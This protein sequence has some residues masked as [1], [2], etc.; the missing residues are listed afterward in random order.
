MNN[1]NDSDS[2]CKD[3]YND[4]G[5]NENINNKNNN[6][7]NNNSNSNNINSNNI[8]SNNNRNSNTP[9]IKRTTRKPSKKAELPK[10][11]DSLLVELCNLDPTFPE[12]KVTTLDVD[13]S[14]YWS[15]FRGMKDGER[16]NIYNKEVWEAIGVDK[17]K[18]IIV[19]TTI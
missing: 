12:V 16:R 13:R 9:N 10:I 1:N 11:T 18:G 8:N 17:C 5:S 2:D 7:N 4:S 14:H 6:R 19:V 15:F 3:D